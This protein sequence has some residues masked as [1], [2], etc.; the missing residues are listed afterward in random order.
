MAGGA[1]QRLRLLF[2]RQHQVLTD[3]LRLIEAQGRVLQAQDTER[4]A[5]QLETERGLLAR[6]E[7]LLKAASG[8]ESA[9][10]AACPAGDPATE[11]ARARAAR[12]AAAVAATE[13]S[14][15]GALESGRDDVAR[16]LAALRRTLARLPRPTGTAPRIV[17]ISG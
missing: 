2:D 13:Q 6:L 14:R 16:R 4:L 10:R 3:Y 17:D 8:L 12:A 7:G 11:S 9:Y 15:R 1:A 5:E